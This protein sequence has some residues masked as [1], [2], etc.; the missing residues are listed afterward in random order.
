MTKVPQQPFE[1]GDVAEYSC[2]TD[3]AYIDPTAVLWFVDGVPVNT[4][5]KHTDKNYL[6][7]L[8]YQTQINKST[9]IITAK[10]EMNKKEVKCVL[11]NDRTK[12]N[13]HKLNVVCKYLLDRCIHMKKFEE[14][15]SSQWY[16]L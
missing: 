1:E 14:K 6:S 12:L 13:T 9:L 16:Y 4:N 2:E 5:D 7:A 8:H 10:R 15:D 11:R 3:S